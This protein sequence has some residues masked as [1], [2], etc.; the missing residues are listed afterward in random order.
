MFNYSILGEIC[1]IVRDGLVKRKWHKLYPE[2][3]LMPIRKFDF[4]VVQIGKECYG[5]LDVV[6][7]GKNYKLIIGNYVS[8][9]ENV[10]FLLN[11]EHNI[12][13]ISTYPY[14]VR[15]LQNVERE[16]IG[17]GNIV[18]EDDVWIGYNSII[19]SGVTIGQGAVI[20]AGAV[21]T[22]DVPAY[23]V[24]G[25]NPAKVIKYRFDKELIDK[26]IT[27][28]YSKL[29]KELIADH[30]DELYEELTDASQLDWLPK[31]NG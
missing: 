25:G 4:S 5:N 13:R 1:A 30:I 9:A 8:I 19:M 12:K 10:T 7:D 28:D 16:A 31:K 14:K 17:K 24:V 26:L 2:S 20:A 15:I 23:A 27:V 22:K 18:V 11:A 6:S 3:K 21:V 29:D